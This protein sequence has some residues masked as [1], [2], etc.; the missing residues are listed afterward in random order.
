MDIKS[1]T[2]QRWREGNF[3]EAGHTASY[4]IQASL[5]WTPY[6]EYMQAQLIRC[7]PGELGILL[8]DFPA[9]AVEDNRLHVHPVSDRVITV[10]KGKGTFIARRSGGEIAKIA[11][12]PGHRVWMPRGV[13]HTF[14][15]GSE[16]LL[17]E[18]LHNPFVHF[19]DP[20]VLVYPPAGKEIS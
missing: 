3:V 13:L 16:G 10:I 2:R 19:E 17:V 12:D 4:G 7:V 14:L 20:R 6:E 15:A 8:V 11:L 5:P 9:D 18:S 1:E